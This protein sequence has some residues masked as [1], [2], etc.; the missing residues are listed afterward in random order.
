MKSG[1]KEHNAGRGG[2]L[3]SAGEGVGGTNFSHSQQHLHDLHLVHV[4]LL[5]CQPH[6]YLQLKPRDTHKQRMGRVRFRGCTPHACCTSSTPPF[7]AGRACF[8]SL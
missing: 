6:L 2:I 7:A 8:T 3:L 5:P 1:G 4:K